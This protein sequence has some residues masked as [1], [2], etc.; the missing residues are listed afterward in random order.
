LPDGRPI[1]IIVE[2]AGERTEESDIL[3]LV[4]DTWAEIGVA[5]F[6]NVSQREVFR[7]RVFAGDA[8]MSMWFGYDNGIFTAATVPNELAPVDQNWLQYPKWGQY[9]QTRG[10]AGEPPDLDWGQR[11]MTLYDEWR[12]NPDPEAR[13]AMTNEMLDI[14]ADQVDVIGIV[15]G[16]LQPVVVDDAL[17]NVPAD[18]LYSWDPG[19]HFGMYQ[20]AAFWLDPEG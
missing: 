17:R 20:P 16:V 7:N 8:L 12:A 11:L 9:V 14:H 4:A 6:P 18:G 3:E 10:E 19:A 13:L 15:Q 5:V 1:E 2:L